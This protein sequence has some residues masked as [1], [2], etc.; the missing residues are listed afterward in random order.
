MQSETRSAHVLS[1]SVGGG[2][3]DQTGQSDYTDR[4]ISMGSDSLS[5]TIPE[6]RP[7]LVQLAQSVGQRTWALPS[8]DELIDWLD[9]MACLV[10]L[11]H[12][13]EVSHRAS[14]LLL[15]NRLESLFDEEPVE[16]CMDHPAQA[17][18]QEALESTDHSLVLDGLFEFVS[19]DTNP[20]FAA[21]VLRCLSR[22]ELTGYTEWQAK[23]VAMA[24]TS[25]FLETRDAGVRAAE[26]WADPHLTELLLSHEEPVAW[27][28]DYIKDVIDDLKT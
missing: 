10:V 27:L 16:D 13:R 15:R 3:I 20:C 12:E 25:D 17:V 9:E 1:E 21:S 23:F 11:L 7:G 4:I 14:K 8:I 6:D 26:S 5:A 22:L 18:M 24:L 2:R 28:R 19:S